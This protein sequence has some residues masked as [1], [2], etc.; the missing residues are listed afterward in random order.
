MSNARIQ[1]ED[2]R[3]HPIGP[4]VLKNTGSIPMING[5][6]P[7]LDQDIATKAYALSVLGAG[8][9]NNLPTDPTTGLI[10]EGTSGTSMFDGCHKLEGITLLDTTNAAQTSDMFNNCDNLVA[11]NSNDQ[12][13][14]LAGDS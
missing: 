11:P 7:N 13:N 1:L 2:N 6:S 9:L 8:T 10:D 4:G 5:Y 12:S 3:E 14:L